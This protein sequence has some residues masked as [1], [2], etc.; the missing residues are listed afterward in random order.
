[1][2]TVSY[3]FNISVDKFLL[4][5]PF[6]FFPK[7]CKNRDNFLFC[8]IFRVLRRYFFGASSMTATMNFHHLSTEGTK[9]RSSGE[10]GDLSVG[11]QE[12]MS[13]LG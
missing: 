1:M 5:K 4:I 2:K 7:G 13:Q 10:W 12:I 3:C 11:P 9:Q 6:G 8:K